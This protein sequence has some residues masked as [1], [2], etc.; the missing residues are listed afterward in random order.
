MNSRWKIQ[1]LLILLSLLFV[2]CQRSMPVG[3][4]DKTLL[5]QATDLVPYGYGFQHIA[6]HETF[7]KTR[8]FDGTV[9]VEYEFETP[10]SEHEHALYLN[11]VITVSRK[12]NDA[13]VSQGAENIGIMT[14]LK[15]QGM[16]H[17]E[18]AGFYTYGDSSRFF[19]LKK[20]GKS[21]GNYFSAREG[22]KTYT[23]LLAGM[24]IEDAS[25]W[26]ELVEPKLQAF[27]R[28]KP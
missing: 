22:A 9:E 21:V 11:V 12:T 13:R 6:K 17:E 18:K 1:T 27:S 3:P 5:L 8:D 26:K 7:K 2:Q 14:G 25:I 23:I 20:D 15:L 19:I 24:Y 16:V 4:A 28:Y 10:D